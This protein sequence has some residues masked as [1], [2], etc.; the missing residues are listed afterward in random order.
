MRS[1]HRPT[2]SLRFDTVRYLI[3]MVGIAIVDGGAKP[4]DVGRRPW[5]THR[6]IAF[7]LPTRCDERKRTLRQRDAGIDAQVLT[8]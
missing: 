1:R 4:F 2:S 3:E 8:T 7:V 6:S 5:S